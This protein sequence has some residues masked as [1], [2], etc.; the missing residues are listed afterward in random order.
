MIARIRELLDVARSM[1][2]RRSVPLTYKTEAAPSD[3][4]F[5]E[6][7]ERNPAYEFVVVITPDLIAAMESDIEQAIAAQHALIVEALGLRL[8][9]GL[10]PC[11]T[12]ATMQ[13][14]RDG[15]MAV[16]FARATDQRPCVGS[17][18]AREAA[19]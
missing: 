6:A 16:H 17:W 15:H 3:L 1:L 5:R 7:M 13:Q 19:A 2:R 11:Q 4:S 18:P 14:P 8:S 12:C 9:P 10:V